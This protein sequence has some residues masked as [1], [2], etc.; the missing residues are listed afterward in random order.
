[1]AEIVLVVAEQR[2]GKLNSHSLEALVAGQRT[3]EANKLSLVVALLGADPGGGAAGLSGYRMDRLV[4]LADALLEP[5]NPDAY[6]GVVHALVEEL[7]PEWVYF[8]HTYQVRDFAAR[9]AARSGRSL[10]SDCVDIRHDGDQTVFVRQVYQGRFHADVVA[11]GEAPRFASFQ[12]AAFGID[13]LQ[14]ASGACQPET[15]PVSLD[16]AAIRVRA[17]QPAQGEAASVDLGKADIIVSVGRGIQEAENIEIA[18]QLAAAMGGELGASRPV[19]DEGWLP[20]ER[21]VGSSGQTVSPKLY[22]ALGIS[23][24]SQHLVGMKGSKTIVAV[25]KDPKAPIF[26]E[27]DYGITGDVLEVI[28][29]LIKALE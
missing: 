12:A 23:G 6:C 25:N 18:Q 2:Q 11:T 7:S 1:M 29:A 14:A 13:Q 4:L 16:T 26:K 9:V 27:A 19:C 28:P 10:I 21:Q 17:E 8:P 22:L 20:L 5:Y 24:A 15:L 3:A